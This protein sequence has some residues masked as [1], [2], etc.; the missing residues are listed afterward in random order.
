MT[1]P[2]ILIKNGVLRSADLKENF[3]LQVTRDCYVQTVHNIVRA[4]EEYANQYRISKAT[5]KEVAPKNQVDLEDM[6]K[7]VEEKGK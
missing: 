4:M 1:A 3:N 2:E 6:I 7:D 5:Q